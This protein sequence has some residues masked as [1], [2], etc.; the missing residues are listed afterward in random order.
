MRRQVLMTP[1][2]TLLRATR[3]D[4]AAGAGAVA[5]ADTEATAAAASNV[6][7][8]VCSSILEIILLRIRRHFGPTEV[9]LTIS[10]EVQETEVSA[11]QTAMRTYYFFRGLQTLNSHSRPL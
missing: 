5:D 3:T 7:V 4:M 9:Q 11:Q 1:R 2:F 8:V 6:G 10:H